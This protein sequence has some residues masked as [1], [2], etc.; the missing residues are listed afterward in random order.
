MKNTLLLA[1]GLLLT[2]I[3]CQT[4]SLDIQ[5]SFPFQLTIDPFPASI[6]WQKPTSVGFGVKPTYITSNNVYTFSWQVAAPV[7]GVL[8]LN[9]KAVAPG[10]KTAVTASLNR[11]LSDTLTYVPTDSGAHEIRVRV[12]DSM[13]QARDTT[14]TITA[15]RSNGNIK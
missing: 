14:F 5:R 11:V 10:A 4:E 3:A 12:F 15:I 8:L 1:C 9:N 6:P 7:R 2:G 13:G